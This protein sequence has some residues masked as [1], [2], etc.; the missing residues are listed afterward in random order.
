MGN[1]LGNNATVTPVYIAKETFYP[2]TDAF[3]SY[4]YT[5][6]LVDDNES[7]KVWRTMGGEEFVKLVDEMPLKVVAG[8]KLKMLREATGFHGSG[9]TTLYEMR[10]E[11]SRAVGLIP[12]DLVAL[13]GTIE[14]EQ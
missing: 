11:E 9:G 2:C 10:N 4:T 13:E 1:N 14:C 12:S 3:S 7:N 5:Y 8:D 6:S